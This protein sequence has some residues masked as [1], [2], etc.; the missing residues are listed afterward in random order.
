MC[1]V[2]V[3]VKRYW[4]HIENKRTEC[5]SLFLVFRSTWMREMCWSEV[6][7]KN[8]REFSPLHRV[9]LHCIIYHRIVHQHMQPCMERVTLFHS[10][11]WLDLYHTQLLFTFHFI[12]IFFRLPSCVYSTLYLLLVDSWIPVFCNYIAYGFLLFCVCMCLRMWIVSFVML[13]VRCCCCCCSIWWCYVTD[14]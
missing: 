6:M 14:S 2:F 1:V 8:L 13:L 10:G 7:N 12:F 9:A 5:L 3:C 11:Y 4:H